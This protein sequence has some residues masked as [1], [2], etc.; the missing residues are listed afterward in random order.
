MVLV[1]TRVALLFFLA[2]IV[3]SALVAW[4]YGNHANYERSALNSFT[5]IVSVFSL[6]VTYMFYYSIVEIAQQQQKL[7]VIHETSRLDA[8]IYHCLLEDINK[9]S[10]DIPGFVWTLHPMHQESQAPPSDPEGVKT[11][12]ARVA[13]S[14]KIFITWQEAM[15]Y[16]QFTDFDTSAYLTSFLQLASSLPLEEEWQ[17]TRMNYNPKTRRFADLLFAYAPERREDKRIV[18]HEAG[19]YCKQAQALQDDDDYERIRYWSLHSKHR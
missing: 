17:K 2:V 18:H 15:S 13:L 3:L 4:S 5:S 7:L 19:W 6:L 10:T 8:D 11:A 1:T 16:K 14:H 12:A 9:Y